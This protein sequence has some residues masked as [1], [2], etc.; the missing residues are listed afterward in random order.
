MMCMKSSRS[1]HHAHQPKKKPL[2]VNNTPFLTKFLLQRRIPRRC[3]GCKRF[4]GQYRA[5]D[6]GG[7]KRRTVVHR[8]H[9]PRRETESHHAL[10]DRKTRGVEIPVVTQI[11]PRLQKLSGQQ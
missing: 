10:A 2:L 8:A 7:G 9:A 1:T 6:I 4:A 5:F 3:P 11:G